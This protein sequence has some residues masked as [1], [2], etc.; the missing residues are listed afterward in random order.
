M[1]RARGGSS[2]AIFIIQRHQVNHVTIDEH[3]ARVL[4]VHGHAVA[5]HGLDLPHAPIL[6]RGMAD[7]QAGDED[8]EAL[9]HGI[10]PGVKNLEGAVILI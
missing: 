1:S 3:L 9:C 8:A 6:L 2:G 7:P 5:D 10:V 4:E